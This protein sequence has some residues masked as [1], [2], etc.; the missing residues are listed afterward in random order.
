MKPHTAAAILAV[1]DAHGLPR[2]KEKA[3]PVIQAW[4]RAH[5]AQLD[6]W[7]NYHLSDGKR[8]KFLE[9]VV[10]TEEKTE[11]GWALRHS[12]SYVAVALN[13]A[14]RAATAAGRGDIERKTLKTKET[15]K[16]ASERGALKR[17]EVYQ[18]KNGPGYYVTNGY[19]GHGMKMRHADHDKPFLSP[20][21]AI[22]MAKKKY[23]ELVGMKFLYLL[24]VQVVRA[25]DRFHAETPV[26][27]VISKG[28]VELIWEDGHHVAAPEDPNQQRLPGMAKGSTNFHAIKVGDRVTIRVP[29]GIG[30]KGQEWS[31]K[32]GRVVM[33]GTYGWA[34]DLGGRHGTP[35]VATP[36]N[37]VRIQRKKT[38]AEG[39]CCGLT[40][41]KR[42]KK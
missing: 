38:S 31:E 33:H 25:P 5:D 23:A 3:E 18:I 42:R 4:L 37:F 2:T 9:R 39:H 29:A 26:A 8:V 35:G 19:N 22:E 36:E 12:D 7:G 15:R 34:L 40:A 6:R 17:N 24:P 16:A 32:T 28:D 20:D 41:G 21:S 30:R 1:I 27:A 13:L 14:K 10:R 11:Y